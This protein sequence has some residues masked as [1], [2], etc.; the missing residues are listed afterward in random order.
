MGTLF[1]F[2]DLCTALRGVWRAWICLLGGASCRRWVATDAAKGGPPHTFAL[3]AAVARTSAL[4]AS[5]ECGRNH[6]TQNGACN[7]QG[8]HPWGLPS[9]TA[10]ACTGGEPIRKKRVS[11]ASVL[12]R[13]SLAA[14]RTHLR[15]TKAFAKLRQLGDVGCDAPRLVAR[16]QFVCRTPLIMVPHIWM[17]DAL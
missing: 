13:R 6:C 17:A 4:S 5:C 9:S 2:V 12:V 8:V 11:G 14:A 3:G 15:P 7:Y 10:Y 1:H 16:E